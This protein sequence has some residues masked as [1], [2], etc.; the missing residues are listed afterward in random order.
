V[1]ED[2]ARELEV[3]LKRKEVPMD[4]EFWVKVAG[5]E[6]IR[7]VVLNGM[8]Y[9]AFIFLDSINTHFRSVLPEPEL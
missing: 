1:K 7:E 5:Q 8:L 9:P 2:R 4:K 3:Q 6:R